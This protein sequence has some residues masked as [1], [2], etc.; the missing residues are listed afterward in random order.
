M[1]ASSEAKLHFIQILAN[2]GH[3]FPDI[4]QTLCC[5]V[6]LFKSPVSHRR[7]AEA[8]SALY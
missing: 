3:Y 5:L 6:I 1:S 8:F 7:L 4:T 2:L